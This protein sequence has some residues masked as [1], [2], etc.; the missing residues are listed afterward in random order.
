M[1]TKTSIL[2][3]IKNLIPYFGLIALYFFF[4]N[5]EVNKNSDNRI[6]SYDKTV[7]SKKNNSNNVDDLL[8]IKIPVIP[9][10]K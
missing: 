1:K 9:F 8:K 2:V 3:K 4:V 10:R 7:D 6:N 5:I